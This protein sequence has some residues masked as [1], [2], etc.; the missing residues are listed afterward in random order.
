MARPSTIDKLPA[1]ILEQ[2]QA[3]LRDPRITQ[4]DATAEINAILEQQGHDSVSK[5]AVNR[6][7]IRM[8][9]VGAKLKHSR[10]VDAMWIGKLG[11]APQGQVGKLLNEI[12]R[13]MAFYTAMNM[14]ESE[15][16]VAPKLLSQLALVVQ[17]LEAAA[18]MNEERDVKIR[19]NERARN[20]DK[21]EKVA[22]EKGLTK[23]SVA[24]IRE[25]LSAR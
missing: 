5:S 22:K 6:Y 1:D 7:S 13:T 3:L 23:L 20:Q 17:R 11:N 15:E 4:L 19:E 9:D 24:Q 2:L 12:I 21:L 16:P 14:S 18:N 8:E 25:A 10:E